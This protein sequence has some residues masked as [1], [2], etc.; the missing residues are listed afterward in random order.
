METALFIL[1]LVISVA[2]VVAV[3]LQPSK[4]EGLGS[5]GGGAQLFFTAH[6]GWEAFLDRATTVLAVLFMLSSLALALLLR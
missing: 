1:Q 4:G 3:L 6:K 5:I 2:L